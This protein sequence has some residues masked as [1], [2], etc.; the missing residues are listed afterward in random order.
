MVQD[1]YPLSPLQ[2]GML[3]HH[4][5]ARTRGVDVEQLEVRLNEPIDAKRLADAWARV[6]K[7]H[8][9]LRTRFRWE[10]LKAPLQ[11]VL[12]EIAVPFETRDLSEMTAQEQVDALKLFFAEDRSRAFALDVA[13]LWRVT[14]LRLG[15]DSHQLVFTYS[16]A[17]LDSC[18][19]SI[20][21]EVFDVYAAMARGEPP[22]FA[23]RPAYQ[24]HI[25]WLQRHL[26]TNA[27]AAEAYWRNALAGF[28]TPTNLDA[29]R[30]AGRDERPAAGHATLEFALSPADTG[31]LHD[32]AHR[33]SLRTSVFV[34]VAWALVLSAFAAQDD[35]VYG[36]TRAC[37]RSSIEG[38]DRVIGLF[39][40][41]VPIRVKLA[42]ELS[43]LDL[44]RQLR[45]QRVELRRFEYTPLVDI[46]HLSEV[47]RG[48]S[49]F[50]SIIVFNSQTDDARLKSFG[51][52]W[53]RRDFKLHDQ[54][55]FPFNVMAY[56]GPQ[57][58]F[59]LS[60][61]TGCFAPGA[62][63]RIADLLQAIF[64]AIAGQPETKVGDLPRLPSQDARS[65]LRIWNDTARPLPGPHC[66]HEAFEAQVDRTPDKVALVDGARSLTYRELDRR[67]N[68]VARALIAQG[69]GPDQMVG[70]YVERSIEMLV[71]LLGIL[72][73]GAA[74]VPMDPSY[75]S[76][77]IALM[78]EDSRARVVV[79]TTNLAGS[80]PPHSHALCVDG[81]LAEGDRPRVAV[82]GEHLAY[83][84]FTSGST[85]RPKGVMLEHRNVTS[86]FEAM[87][88]VLGTTPGVWLATTSISFD[89]SVL[90]LFWTL[91]RGFTV[92]IQQE[93]ERQVRAAA[94]KGVDARPI[95]FSLFYF[96]ADAAETAGGKYRLLLEGAKYA[97]EHGFSA[98]WTP[99]RHF[100]PFGGLYPNAALTGAAVAAVTRRIGIRAGSVVL[101]LHNPIRVAEE[102]SVV[103]NLSNGRVGLSFASGWHARDF[104]LQP[105]NYKNR[106]E[107]MASGIETVKALWRGEAVKA[108]G[109]DGQPVEVKTYPPPVQREPKMWVTASSHPDTFALAGRLGANVL[110]NLLVM[111]SEQLVE[112][113]A[114]Y[115]K[116]WTDAGHQG[117][118]VVTLMLHTFVGSDV[119]EVRRKVRAPFLEY[120]K[121][122]TDLISKMRW[123]LTAFAKGSDRDASIAPQMSLADL[124][125][126][127]L[128]VIM[129]HAFERYFKTAG[130][131]GSPTPCLATIDRLKQFGVDEIACLIDFGVAADEVLA[132][133]PYL[134]E[135]RRMANRPQTA[136]STEPVQDIAS[137]IRRH[138]VSHL[139][140]TP[141]LASMLVSDEASLDALSSLR[142]L[143][144]GGEPLPRTLLERLRKSYQGD[145]RNMY[146]PTETCIWST[147]S[148]VD[149]ADDPITIGKPIANTRVYVVDRSLRPLPVG[150]PGEILI[151]GAGVARGYLERPEL[152]EERFVPDSFDSGARLY[153]TGDLG[154]W[155]PDGT[156][157]Y[158]G[159]LDHQVKIRGH[160]IEPGEIEAALN[161][162]PS[163]QQS[164]V[165]A[166]PDAT[167][168][169]QL[170]AYIVAPSQSSAP[171]TAHWGII[172]DETYQHGA[173][174]TAG[175]RSSYT[176]DPIPEAQMREW[177]ACT[178]ARIQGLRPRRVLELGCGTGMV[179]F[180]I[181]P[182]CE[183][184]HGIDLSAAA[185]ARVKAEADRRGLRGVVLEQ[186]AA[187]TLASLE[188]GPFDTI[189][190]NSVAQYFPTVEYL[191]D[192]LTAAIGRLAPG[193]AIFV[194]DVRHRALLEVML[195]EIELQNATFDTPAGEL[196]ARLRKR[197]DEEPELVLDPSLFLSLR[198][199][200]S[201]VE[202]VQVELKLGRQ[203]SEMTRFR[204]DVVIR[205]R[206]G[207]PRLPAVADTRGAPEPCT[208]ESLKTMVR[209]RATSLRITGIPNARVSV[210]LAALRALKARSVADRLGEIGAGPS[211][212]DPE[213]VRALDANYEVAIEWSAAGPG[214]FDAIFR[215]RNAQQAAKAPTEIAVTE[216]D[217]GLADVSTY[218]NR[219][220]LRAVA[221]SNLVPALRQ[222]LR[223]T[224]PEYM[225]PSAFV[226]LEALPLTPNGKLDRQALPAPDGARHETATP[227]VP[228]ATDVERKLAAIFQELLGLSEIGIDDNFFD[229]GANSL[230]MVRVVEKIRAE[231]G[232]KMSV[233]R[234]FQFPTLGSLAAA[235]A[236]SE[237]DP[238]HVALPPEQNRGQLRREMMQRRRETRGAS[239]TTQRP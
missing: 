110:T 210:P 65:T 57:L 147:T 28:R 71:G 94:T 198:Q 183:L 149:G 97:D 33:E 128:D 109:G 41:T 18:Y 21:K 145:I 194:G 179:L 135:L 225:I 160:R 161:R 237:T 232:L 61:D 215:L 87:D 99:E 62:V 187:D 224:L 148:P 186:R 168:A 75:P 175:W 44:C 138:G 189:V 16:H 239:R 5:E 216:S 91:A 205:K 3:F 72:K 213:D 90:E 143:L 176:G 2:Q 24:E 54:T 146:G 228:P 37:R 221:G 31:R 209:S 197:L 177:I 201:D 172:W 190:I 47:S 102:W 129:E 139:Q 67:A 48:Q 219:P 104:V 52:E 12:G 167:G 226:P 56:D 68:H 171:T 84:I 78:L 6:A 93:A 80:L 127:E 206:G 130:L 131:F 11:D 35:V 105:D 43:V 116:A 151:G 96:A 39:I 230:M 119:E 17:I 159:R 26:A 170:V 217:L 164:A 73:A 134:D 154:Q 155:L 150:V 211:G 113:I 19:A 158:L 100:H 10:G 89:I 106:R 59:K 122:S 173:S 178:I 95:D 126:E 195:S 162:H 207:M 120:L 9:I 125:A 140:A 77:R 218:A 144:L 181:A 236:G 156:L 184:Y 92:V 223:S 185:L 49:L 203:P 208:L 76:E 53:Q 22:S 212:I 229:L 103:D 101:P 115:R 38:A 46:L 174:E 20:V 8:P 191:M 141:S 85:G 166:R 83:V 42:S 163:V 220:A 30:I 182:G 14:L 238:G 29:L 188:G 142:M 124:D 108:V 234:V 157:A 169:Q 55:N 227:F 117:A 79:T 204:Y 63:E 82:T 1:S 235:I 111:K 4:L 136:I 112:N 25:A 133:L 231:M 180:G 40:N 64:V 165:V 192:V 193:G 233:V 199:R 202:D 45:E 118:G 58:T 88:Q 81:E 27:S 153:R 69:A 200:F 50:E 137:Q 23:E 214:Y 74:Y 34:E 123:E 36:L 98:V 13:P 114:I 66:V 222:H 121:T 51:E 86:F 132:S 152:T 196:Q 60:Y 70:I 15:A 7:Q 32:L 107:L